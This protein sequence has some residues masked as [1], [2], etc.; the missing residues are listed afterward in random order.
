MRDELRAIKRDHPVNGED[1]LLFRRSR[2][3][4]SQVAID[5]YTEVATI[6]KTGHFFEFLSKRRILNFRVADTLGF[7]RTHRSND[8]GWRQK[9]RLLF[10]EKA[11]AFRVANARSYIVNCNY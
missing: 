1:F 8:D 11:S 5:G 3:L 6:R 2:E 9:S 4:R 7:H 10:P